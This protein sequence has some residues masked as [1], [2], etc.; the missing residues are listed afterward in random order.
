MDSFDFLAIP[1]VNKTLVLELARC[2]FLPFHSLQ[3]F[4][5]K[6]APGVTSALSHRCANSKGI[7]LAGGFEL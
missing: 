5:V 4:R 7:A 6:E 2:E 1:S 3:K